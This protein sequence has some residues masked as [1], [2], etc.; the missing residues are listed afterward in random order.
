MRATTIDILMVL[1]VALGKG[2]TNFVREVLVTAK[3]ISHNVI[4]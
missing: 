2:S 4:W 3:K 1:L